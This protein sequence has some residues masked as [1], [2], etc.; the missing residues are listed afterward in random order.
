VLI[1]VVTAVAI[2]V[3]ISGGWEWRLAGR[4]VSVRSVGNL[5]LAAAILWLLR[6]LT[7]RVTFL[8]RWREAAD[9]PEPDSLGAL[10]LT[11]TGRTRCADPRQTSGSSIRFSGRSR[12]PA[13]ETR[14]RSSRRR[15]SP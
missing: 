6:L 5:L 2:A 14:S 15:D 11:S 1:V 10:S 13:C 8:W 4:T 9:E 3:V 7:P 12:P